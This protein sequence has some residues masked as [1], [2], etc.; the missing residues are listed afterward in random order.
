M[1][2]S[3]SAPTF[4]TSV[5]LGAVAGATSKT[6]TVPVERVRLLLQMSEHRAASSSMAAAVL[7][8][9]GASG[10]WRGNGLAVTRAIM[11]KGLLFATQ[12]H[13]RTVLGSEAIAGSIAGATAAGLTYPLDLLRTR[14][15][16]QV[17]SSSLAAVS[18]QALSLAHG[19]GVLALW[20]GASAT[21][22]GGVVFEG[23]RFGVFGW[24]RDQ[25][26]QR[27]ADRAAVPGAAEPGPLMR[28][29]TSPAALGT[30][31]SLVGGNLIYPNDT[32][33]RR[34]QSVDGRGESYAQATAHLLR[35]GG[36]SRLYRGLLLYNLK[37]APSAA[38][39]FFAHHEL[40]RLVMR[41]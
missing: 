21:L 39:Q 38:V 11:Q 7:K 30:V 10:L 40:K 6:V 9:E 2:A 5:V 27:R 33:R 4:T 19:G 16:G 32:V 26:R 29:L 14:L 41:Q 12:D 18:Q 35:E 17:G 3:E 20:T 28:L 31:A 24:L 1:P 34:L 25:D 15:A 13:L 22:M 37:A 8:R 23:V 36:V